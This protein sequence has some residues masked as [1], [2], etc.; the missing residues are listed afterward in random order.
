VEQTLFA[1]ASLA[2][3]ACAFAEDSSAE[4]SK[5]TA[6]QS[7][8]LNGASSF[9]G[10]GGYGGGYGGYGGGY[11]SNYGGGLGYGSY[12]RPGYGNSQG[13]SQGHYFPII[14]THILPST[15]V[16]WSQHGFR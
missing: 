5:I 7:Q 14:I 11:G 9:F 1:L 15:T 13:S 8:D 2:V 4:S 6:K 12:Y 3:V 16:V 10:G